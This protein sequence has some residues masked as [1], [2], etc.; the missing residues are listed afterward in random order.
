MNWPILTADL[1]KLSQAIPNSN[2]GNQGAPLLHFKTKYEILFD[3]L[4]AVFGCMMS[5]SRLCEQTHGMMRHG[6][7]TSVGMEQA[8]NQRAYNM[9]TG[10]K[11]NEQR[12]KLVLDSKGKVQERVKK[13]AKHSATKNQLEFLSF[14]IN[15]HSRDYAELV[16]MEDGLLESYCP[17][18][19]EINRNG[20]R[21][22][23]KEN[24]QRQ[25]EQEKASASRLTRTHLTIDA[26]EDLAA[27]TRLTNDVL[28]VKDSLVVEWRPKV[29]N[30]LVKKFWGKLRDK[31]QFMEVYGIARKCLI[32][33]HMDTVAPKIE[34]ITSKTKALS[35]IGSY[36]SIQQK[37]YN[38]KYLIL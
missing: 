13:S 30:M 36:V 11:L 9:N 23:D 8:D 10:Y 35:V 37:H 25:I 38:P 7:R 29:K 34:S 21:V 33:I 16:A 26:I 4:E 17:S 27:S 31:T 32:H 22:Q 24:L 19:S 12:R 28:F 14:Q 15:E 5:N 18:N 6:L 2:G 20:R 1:Q 3:C